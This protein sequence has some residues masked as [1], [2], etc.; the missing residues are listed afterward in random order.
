MKDLEAL[1]K[2]ELIERAARLMVQAER[3]DLS[4]KQCEEEYGE[5]LEELAE[6]LKDHEWVMELESAMNRLKVYEAD[7]LYW[8]G[9]LDGVAL[10]KLLNL[11]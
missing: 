10:L 4:W 7:F 2:Q 3:E 9:V 11:F 5:Y 6:R 8:Q 1:I